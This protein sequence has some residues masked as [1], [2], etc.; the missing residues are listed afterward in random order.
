MI[1]RAGVVDLDRVV[2]LGAQFLAYGPYR[3]IPLDPEAFRD[4]AGRLVEGGVI[5]L[6]EDGML[7]GVLN[8]FFFNPAL[9]SAVELFW[10][11][12][13]TGRAL[14]DAF[15]AWAAEEGAAYLQFSGLVDARARASERLFRRAG[16]RP[17][18]TA[19]LKRIDNRWR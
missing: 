15:E 2:E 4:F 8:P 11:G 19:Y 3:E 10:W 17:T 18:E 12:P 5:F 7:G 6:S 16:F 14:R 1:R 9:V 13:T